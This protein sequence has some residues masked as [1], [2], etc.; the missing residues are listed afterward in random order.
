MQNLP[1]ETI[2]KLY[3]IISISS[4]YVHMTLIIRKKKLSLTIWTCGVNF[5]AWRKK[6]GKAYIGSWEHFTCF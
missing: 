6:I 3:V 1:G 4:M 5:L 2:S